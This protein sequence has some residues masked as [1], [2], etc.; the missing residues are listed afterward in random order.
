MGKL[1][2]GDAV[3]RI[4]NAGL[5]P[6]PIYHLNPK[7]PVGIKVWCSV[8]LEIRPDNDGLYEE[9]GVAQL[10]ANAKD[11]GKDE[12]KHRHDPRYGG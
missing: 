9:A 3:T 10:I 1:Y 11:W 12:A 6:E 8:S 7:R 5:M 2:Y 4:R